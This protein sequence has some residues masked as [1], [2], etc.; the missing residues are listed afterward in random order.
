MNSCGYK[1]RLLLTSLFL[2]AIIYF[3]WL[4]S[5]AP[6]QSADNESPSPLPVPTAQ[7]SFWKNIDTHWGGRF[8]TTGTGLR[9]MDDTIFSP[10]GTGN[11]YDGSANLRL[12]NETFFTDSVFFEAD[13]ELFWTGGDTIRKQNELK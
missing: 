13:Y 8:K 11:D 5:Y 3:Q 6:A 7:T 1:L 10:V 2:V 4:S 9:V 12:I